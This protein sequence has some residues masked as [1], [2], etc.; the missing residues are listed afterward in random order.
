MGPGGGRGRED[1]ADRMG[2]RPHKPL[3]NRRRIDC[4]GVTGGIKAA[5]TYVR[6]VRTSENWGAS[7]RFLSANWPRQIGMRLSER[8]MRGHAWVSVCT[9][10]LASRAMDT[11]EIR[12]HMLPYNFG[13]ATC[14]GPACQELYQ[15]ISSWKSRRS[16]RTVSGGPIGRRESGSASRPDVKH[17]E[18]S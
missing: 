13:D 14:W 9:V 3:R 1:I 16:G 2:S 18:N 6:G 10:P 4:R 7:T 12:T 15:L 5:L 17:A 11:A 8:R